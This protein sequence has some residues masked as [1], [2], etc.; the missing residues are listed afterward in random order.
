MYLDKILK[1]IENYEVLG[2]SLGVEVSTVCWDTRL[3]SDACLFV[4]NIGENFDALEHIDIIAKQANCILVNSSMKANVEVL[5][6]SHRD[7]CFILVEDIEDISSKLADIFF[8][9]L[10]S[11]RLVGVTGTNGKTTVCSLLKHISDCAGQKS[12]LIG[13][14][15]YEWEGHKIKSFMT[16]PDEFNLKSICASMV[17]DEVKN[18]F[19]EV[20]SHALELE[21]LKGL[22]LNIGLFT[23]LSVE[24]LD[25]HK[26]ISA[27]AKAKSKI[28][29]LLVAG[30]KSI[31]NA[32]DEHSNMS[33]LN[34]K[35]DVFRFGIDKEA[36]YKVKSYSLTQEGI[37]WKMLCKDV[38]V[39][40]TSCLVGKFNLYNLI[41]AVAVASEM[42]IGI[43]IIKQAIKSFK[44]PSGRL[45]RIKGNVFVDYAHT[46]D[47]LENVLS[48]LR[49][50]GYEE[51]ITVFGCGGERDRS[52]RAIMAEIAEKL[53]SNV[54]VTDDNPR[55]ENREQIFEDISRGFSSKQK[56][57]Y[58]HDRKEAII[59]ALSICRN[60]MCAVL[61]AGKG[62]EDYQ[63]MSDGVRHFSDQEVIRECL[64]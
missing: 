48:T 54:I 1:N 58:I 11:L 38:D 15:A 63:I 13:T 56:V 62:H 33:V 5:S 4:V 27:Y 14:V 8:K 43:E 17:A 51:I 20:S 46:P 9:D 23:N 64:I 34:S 29:E 41:S 2:N 53:S 44:A 59:H 25:F 61:V 22:G 10:A 49:N 50:I 35:A 12:G 7:I 57:Y 32:D 31:I 47:A 3:M 6:K 39:E 30:G 37:S 24:H 45:E 40:L 19:L 55:S 26:T 36:D 52:K 21:R 28:H 42:G 18:V 60:D 16:T